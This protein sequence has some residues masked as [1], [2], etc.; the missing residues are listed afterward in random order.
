LNNKNI[1]KIKSLYNKFN[2]ELSKDY[3]EINVFSEKALEISIQIIEEID[4]IFD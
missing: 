2:K 1:T 3:K 4:S